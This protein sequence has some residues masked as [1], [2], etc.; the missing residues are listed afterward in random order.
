MTTAPTRGAAPPRRATTLPADLLDMVKDREGFYHAA[1]RCPAG[2]WTIGYGHSRGVT[3]GDHISEARAHELLI[4]D[5]EAAAR[6][7][8]RAV[9]VPLKPYQ[10]AALVSFAF[11]VGGGAK[12]VKDGFAMLKSGQPS[13]LLRKLNA[14]DYE[15]AAA[16]LPKWTK[17]AGTVL[18]GLVLRRRM[19]RLMFEG[20]DWE[21]ALEP[22]RMPQSV[23]APPP[24]MKPLA[25]SVTVRAGAGGL[26][27]AGIV[28][29]LGEARQVRDAVEGALGGLPPGGL[30]WVAAGVLAATVAVMLWRRWDDARKAGAP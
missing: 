5:L 23:D 16:E 20:G 24:P 10:R 28:T 13:T 26:G 4:E 6:I 14:G 15:G 7:V 11:N 21:A 12:G 27:A 9:T 25:Q 30:G 8:D 2:V 3:P 19:E 1:Y 18:A 22:E 17:A 29:A